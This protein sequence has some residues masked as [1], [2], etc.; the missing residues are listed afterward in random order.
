[1]KSVFH[2]FNYEYK[3]VSLQASFSIL[4]TLLFHVILNFRSKNTIL[5]FNIFSIF[6]QESF[7]SRQTFWSNVLV[8]IF[9]RSRK[10]S[11]PSVVC[12]VL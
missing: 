7:Q 3:G 9:L 1:M 8:L 12:F 6:S 10:R 2:D 11:D 5:A 4:T